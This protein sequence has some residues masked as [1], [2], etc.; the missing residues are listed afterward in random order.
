[1]RP[2]GRRRGGGPAHDQVAEGRPRHHEVDHKRERRLAV[3]ATGVESS[4]STTLPGAMKL[5]D[6]QICMSP[7]SLSLHK[8]EIPRQLPMLLQN[9]ETDTASPSLL[10]RDIIM[11]VAQRHSLLS[12]LQCTS[13]R[14]TYASMCTTPNKCIVRA[15]S[16]LEQGLQG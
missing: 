7:R 11:I 6:L 1:M 2:A 9:P 16:A 12:C 14:K 8:R 13:R 15:L 4:G 3:P 10:E 5:A